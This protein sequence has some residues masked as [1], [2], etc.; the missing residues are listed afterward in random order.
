MRIESQT[1]EQIGSKDVNTR[2]GAKKTYSFKVGG[3]WYSTGFKDPKVNAGDVVSFDYNTGSYGNEADP[4]SITKG[5]APAAASSPVTRVI[6]AVSSGKGVFPIPALDGQRS[7][8]R[9]N[10]LTNAR[11]LFVGAAGGKP[12]AWDESAMCDSIINMAR[13]FEAY[14]AGD[15]DAEE[16]AA[17]MAAEKKAA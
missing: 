2:F 6:P 17:E 10:A 1:V 11:E 7:I 14:S 8:I 4:K 9:Q 3:A 13:K 12:M 15:L 5:S 16:V